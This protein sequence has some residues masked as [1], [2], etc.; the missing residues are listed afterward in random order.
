MRIL[1]QREM[2]VKGGLRSGAIAAN[3]DTRLEFSEQR[4]AC[5][6]TFNF[7]H[8]VLYTNLARTHATEHDLWQHGFAI[9]K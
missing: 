1:V 5:G 2:P 7:Y 4:T 3:F 6:I 8:T 9:L